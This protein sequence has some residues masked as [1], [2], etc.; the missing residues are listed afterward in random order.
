MVKFISYTGEYPC[1]CMGILNIEVDGKSYALKHCMRSGGNVSF[2]DEWKAFVTTG[3]WSLDLDE[4]PDLIP[5]QE[6]ITKLV[7]ENVP[8]GCCGGCV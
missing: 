8:Y 6:E 3:E 1:L 5:Y 2:D 7:N 4:Y